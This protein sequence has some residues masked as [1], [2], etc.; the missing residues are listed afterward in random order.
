[1]FGGLVV[2][3]SSVAGTRY[4]R[5]REVA[6]LKTIG[7][8]RAML[9]RMF[10]AEFAVIGCV[11]GLIGS[12]LGAVLSSVFIGELLETRYRFEWMPVVIATLITVVLT[13]GAGWIASMGILSRK[14]LD[15]LRQIES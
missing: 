10:C 3:A 1:M 9:V 5:I 8:T 12:V 13:I 14:P 15:I 4:R 6:I 11:A 2:L 7:A